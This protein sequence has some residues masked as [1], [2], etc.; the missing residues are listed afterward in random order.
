MKK[1]VV[2]MVAACVSALSMGAFM[3]AFDATPAGIALS[4]IVA[5]VAGGWIFY[6]ISPVE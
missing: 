5:G 6:K 3:Q 1:M 4:A 2:V